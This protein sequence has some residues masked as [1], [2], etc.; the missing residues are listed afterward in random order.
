MKKLYTLLAVIAISSSLNAQ[1]AQWNFDA[2]V[3]TPNIGAG[4][5]TLIG[6]AIEN[7][8]TGT[9]ACNCPY[10]A[11][12]PSTGK[13]LTIKTFPVAGTASG[14]AGFQFAVSTAGQSSISVSFDNR[15]SATS[16]RFQQ[17]QYTTDGTT[18]IVLGDNAGALT[19]NFPTSP[20][21]FVM[22]AA[23]D[24]KPN[25]AFR[26]VSI[27]NP[28]T[29]DYQPVGYAATP[30][31]NYAAAGAWRV[32]NFNVSNGPLSI[33]KNEIAGLNINP[34]P[35]TNGVFNVSTNA[36]ESKLITIY[37]LLGK[38]VLNTTTAGITVNVE[39]L[40]AGIYIVKIVEEGKTATR[41][42][43]IK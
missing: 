18:W 11:G 24:N 19:N 17:Y 15:G 5:L 30:P 37:D 34:N 40:N 26:I 38:Q 31:S 12:N 39:N 36:N 2:S 3:S 8:Q 6:G 21:S 10:V 25:F 35:I 42:L 23:C 9:G 27:F 22:P 32:D 16:S 4:T 1:F 20:V 28:A 43:V 33:I 29:N 13:S 7:I 14:T 41:K